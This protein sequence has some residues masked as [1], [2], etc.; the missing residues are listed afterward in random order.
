MVK[1]SFLLLLVC[2]VSSVKHS[3]KYLLTLTTGIRD[4]PE[5]EGALVIDDLQA[6]YCYSDRRLVVSHDA[7]KK[8]I[9]E[10][11]L[12]DQ[13]TRQCFEV[14]PRLYRTRLYNIMEHFNQSGGVHTLQVVRGCNWD[15]ETGETNGYMICGYDGEDLMQLDLKTQ[16]WIPLKPDITSIKQTWDADRSSNLERVDFITQ[17]YPL[18][19]KSYLGYKNNSLLRTVS[20]SVSLL[21]KSPS[22]PVSCFATG[23]YPDTADMFWLRNGEQM[24]EDVDRGEILPNPDGTFQMRVDLYLSSVKAKDWSRYD[25]VFK[26][27]GVK[28]NVITKL[29]RAMIRTNEGSSEMS[30]FV[31]VGLVFLAMAA[32]IIGA[33]ISRCHKKKK[34][35]TRIPTELESWMDGR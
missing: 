22:S 29:D 24:H 11:K 10:Y 27:S 32:G 28:D 35:N 34:K 7:W 21:Q 33:G 25:C 26:L 17:I 19:L 4:F 23:F 2:C 16:T 1:L 15:E 8:L 31:V 20:P 18:W 30:K 13:I 6:T 3:L 12:H 14:L 9:D 5:L